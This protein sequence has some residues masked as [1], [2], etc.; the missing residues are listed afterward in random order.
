MAGPG[1]R[2]AVLKLRPRTLIEL[3]GLGGHYR[4]HPRAGLFHCSK[5]VGTD[6]LS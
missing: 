4:G 1:Q 6:T 3:T 2:W 5:G